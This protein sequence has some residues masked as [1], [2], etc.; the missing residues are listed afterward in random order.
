MVHSADEESILLQLGRGPRPMGLLRRESAL[1]EVAFLKAM[2]RL[3]TTAAIERLP[4]DLWRLADL[5]G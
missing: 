2:F 5:R 3:E 1:A 4:G